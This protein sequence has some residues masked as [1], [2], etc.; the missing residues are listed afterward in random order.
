MAD[1]TR[2][3]LAGLGYDDPDLEQALDDWAGSA[4]FEERLRPGRL[5]P[6][7]LEQPAARPALTDVVLVVAGSAG[8][9]PVS[10]RRDRRPARSRGAGR[11]RPPVRPR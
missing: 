6:V 2:R 10:P 11:R 4:N 9:R 8:E 5:D 7:V 1:E 3:L